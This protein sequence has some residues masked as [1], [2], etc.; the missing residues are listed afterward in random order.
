MVTMT[1]GMLI[2]AGVIY[3]IATVMVGLYSLYT[4]T[5]KGYSALFPVF[6]TFV[7]VPFWCVVYPILTV[8]SMHEHCR[9]VLNQFGKELQIKE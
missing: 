4:S 8:L 1:Y 6:W 9:R 2:I 3:Y 5:A 7:F